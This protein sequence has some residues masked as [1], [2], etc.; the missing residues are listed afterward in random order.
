MMSYG[1]TAPPARTLAVAISDLL[2]EGPAQL[3]GKKGKM[4][5]DVGLSH[6]HMTLPLQLAAE[7]QA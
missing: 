4:P 3:S 5:L 1:Q 2:F 7:M 6:C